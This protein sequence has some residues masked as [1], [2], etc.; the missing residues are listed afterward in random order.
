[1]DHGTPWWATSSGHG[2]TRLSV[3]LIKQGIRLYWSGVGHPQTQ[4]KVERFHRTLKHAVRHHGRPQTL[5]EWENALHHFLKEYNHVRPHEALQMAVPA[6]R[7]HPSPK[8]YNPQPS[9]WE[10]L[11]GAIVKRLNSQGCLDYHHRRYPPVG[12]HFAAKT[13]KLNMWKTDCSFVIGICT[14]GKSNSKQAGRC[15]WHCLFHEH[16]V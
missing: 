3:S 5:S 11:Q 16:K 15:L 6:E 12:G 9:Q 14:F 10:Y 1:M 7:Y 2:L 8:Q 13:C 4:G